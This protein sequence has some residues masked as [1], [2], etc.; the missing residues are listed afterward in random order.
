MIQIWSNLISHG[1]KPPSSTLNPRNNPTKNKN[2]HPKN[3][4]FFATW[5]AAFG[6]NTTKFARR[7]VVLWWG[8]GSSALDIS[9]PWVRPWGVGG[10][11][12]G[13]SEWNTM[14]FSRASLIVQVWKFTRWWFQNMFFYFHPLLRKIPSFTSIFQMGWFNHQLVYHFFKMVANSPTSRVSYWKV[15]HF[16][17]PDLERLDSTLKLQCIQQ[18]LGGGTSNICYFHP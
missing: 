7:L 9:M 18:I 10:H 8:R 3:T 15:P 16:C 2:H 5:A 1:L 4:N 14:I 12:V 11:P 6:A 17:L 13:N